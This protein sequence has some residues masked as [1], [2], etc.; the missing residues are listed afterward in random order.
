MECQKTYPAKIPTSNQ[1]SA[2]LIAIL[3]EIRSSE[4]SSSNSDGKASSSLSTKSLLLGEG[5]E[6]FLFI[7]ALDEIPVGQREEIF[8]FL[9]S[10]ASKRL[11]R[12][13]ILLTSRDEP[14]I[15]ENLTDPIQ[16][17]S[18]PIDTIAVETDIDLYVR[19]ILSSH[20]SLRR[21]SADSKEAIIS[22]L[23]R[24]SNGM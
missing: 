13:R 2:T 17:P 16:W 14:S 24:D 5:K 4:S 22:R 6:V 18:V 8:E 7:D 1:L 11:P 3:Q 10:L 20:H 21:Q 15:R 19:R 23:V 9:N 12:V